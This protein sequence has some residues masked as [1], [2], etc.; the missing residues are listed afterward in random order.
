MG[1]MQFRLLC[2]L[3]LRADHVLL[4]FG[5]GSLRAGRLFIVYLNEG[6]YFGIEPKKWLIEDA[7]NDQIGKDLIRIKK[8][9]FSHNDDFETKVFQVQFDFILAHSIFSHS[10][11]EII[12]TALRN[13]RDSLK[14]GGLIAATFVEG[15]MDSNSNGWVYPGFVNYRSSTIQK[16]VEEAGLFAVRIPWY[17]PK[18]TW[19]IL[20]HQSKFLPNDALMHHLTGVVLFSP[21][22]AESW[23]TGIK[24]INLFKSYIMQTA[25]FLP[26]PVKR[27]L[28]KMVR[29]NDRQFHGLY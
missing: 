22:F 9:T 12:L 20:A 17:H 29:K 19:Y 26:E 18:Q 13:F 27:F 23:K 15:I 1:A 8:P 7:I 16:I 25:Q 10:S 24:K 2:A 21:E 4:D 28:K 5:C 11:R 3:G 14:A 6:R